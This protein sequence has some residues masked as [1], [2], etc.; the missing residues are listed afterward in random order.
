MRW[1][2]T[3]QMSK[4]DLEAH[5]NVRPIRIKAGALGQNL[6]ERYLTVSPQHRIVVNSKL[7]RRLHGEDEV[8][9]A[10]KHLL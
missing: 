1:I 5:A 7:V 2:G 10:A 6:P 4:T 3:R 8:L 9:V